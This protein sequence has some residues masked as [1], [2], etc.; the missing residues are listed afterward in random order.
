MEMTAEINSLLKYDMK[1]NM[2]AR[3]DKSPTSYRRLTKSTVEHLTQRNIPATSPQQPRKEN[4][5]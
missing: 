4:I 3:Q 2:L 5:W 1:K